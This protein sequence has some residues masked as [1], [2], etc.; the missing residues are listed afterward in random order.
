MQ[1]DYVAKYFG[2]DLPTF[3]KLS[4][5]ISGKDFHANFMKCAINAAYGITEK[6][7]LI[8]FEPEAALNYCVQYATKIANL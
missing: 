6:N 3:V 5:P 7:C 1:K 8:N 4:I 2:T